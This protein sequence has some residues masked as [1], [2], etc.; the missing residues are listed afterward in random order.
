MLVLPKR[1]TKSRKNLKTPFSR[2]QKKIAK[3]LQLVN[4]GSKPFEIQEDLTQACQSC[5]IILVK[6]GFNEQ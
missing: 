2:D 6:L 3:E 4:R 1:C 5:I